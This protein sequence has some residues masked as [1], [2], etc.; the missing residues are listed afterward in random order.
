MAAA[1]QKE[2]SNNLRFYYLMMKVAP[3][4]VRIKFN[5]EFA[6]IV[7]QKT[8]YQNKVKLNKLK[9]EKV[10]NAAQWEHLF[11]RTGKASSENFD[12][13]LMICLLRNLADIPIVDIHPDPNST[14]DGAN[15]SRLKYFRNQ[16]A[17]S[18]ECSMSDEIFEVKWKELSET[19]QRIGGNQFKQTCEELKVTKLDEKDKELLLE[20]KNSKRKDPMPDGLNN[21]NKE[22][23]EE[24]K[25]EK[26]KVVETKAIKELSRSVKEENIVAVIGPSGC[27]KST[28]IHYIALN[29]N[30]ADNY[31]IVPVAFASDLI[32][33]YDPSINQIFVYDDVF[34]KFSVDLQLISGWT[35]LSKKIKKILAKNHVKVVM[36]SRSQVFKQRQIRNIKIV[37]TT[38][39]DFTS[40]V[41][42]M[43][44]EERRAIAE[45]YLP[46]KEVENLKLLPDSDCFHFYPLL[47]QLYSRKTSVEIYRFFSNPVEVINDD[48]SMIKEE[49]DQ[50]T[51]GTLALFVLFNNCIS[52]G[53]LS[54][55]EKFRQ[56]LQ[57]IS[58]QCIMQSNFSEKVVESQL[59]S[60]I[61]SY[62]KKVGC[63]YSIIHDKIFDII[64]SFYGHNMFDVVLELA[65]AEI[66]RD[67]FQFEILGESMS[68]CIIK[69]P[70]HNESNYLRRLCKD[71]NNGDSKCV[72]SNRQLEFKTFRDLLIVYLE[73]NKAIVDETLMYLSDSFESPMLDVAGQGYCDLA[74]MLIRM[75][76]NVNARDQE[77]RT[78]L[79]RA[80]ESGHEDMVSLLLKNEG[81]Y[82]LTRDDSLNEG[83][84]PLFVA[85]KKGHKNVVNLFL[86]YDCNPN[87]CTDNQESS[88]HIASQNGHLDIVKVLLRKKANPNLNAVH[89]VTPLYKAAEEGH[90]NVVKYLLEHRADSNKITADVESP[91]FIAAKMGYYEIVHILL[92]YG[93]NKTTN[94]CNL[95]GMSPLYVASREGHTKIVELLLKKGA[96]PKNSTYTTLSPLHAATDMRHNEIVKL[97]L[98]H[99]ADPRHCN[100]DGVSPMMAASQRGYED[101]AEIIRQTL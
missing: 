61:S 70:S 24:W 66:I 82:M 47:C 59:N 52:D 26:S 86:D 96:I 44:S 34:G 27:G 73:K 41:F 76:M 4:A 65:H 101:T 35:T 37:Q 14:T 23:I 3:Q 88:L 36:S 77:G 13:S 54:R 6:P 57:E 22:I 33:F 28:A 95:D 87:I 42:A 11:P 64:V 16:F 60:L 75:G 79:Y 78:P 12:C 67:R 91:L 43:T 68:E 40:S 1:L 31:A 2:E 99:K 32:Q 48:L 10:I 19:I 15:L 29:L 84:S 46:S 55:N 17:H 62:V 51:Y 92:E 25:A 30:E 50:T 39:C 9:M 45:I 83:E 71:I 20:L 100:Q 80:S 89:G 94:G 69:V 21:I 63:Q 53:M 5:S 81:N 93:S 97:L 8:L 74:N 98:N 58:Q 18:T 7:L 49:N 85:S 72:F 56:D 38:V 90:F